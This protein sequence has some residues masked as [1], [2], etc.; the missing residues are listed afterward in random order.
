[1]TQVAFADLVKVNGTTVRTW[2]RKGTPG[3]ARRL[4]ELIEY[5][6]GN[7][8]MPDWCIKLVVPSEEEAAV[9]FN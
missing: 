2:V 6:T 7:A 1:M 9:R 4:V 8:P 5:E 3:L